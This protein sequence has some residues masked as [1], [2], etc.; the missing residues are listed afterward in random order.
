MSNDPTPDEVDRAKRWADYHGYKLQESNYRHKPHWHFYPLPK[1]F[2]GFYGATKGYFT[3]PDAAWHALALAL[4]PVFDSIAPVVREECARQAEL[5][6]TV[7]GG[8]PTT[9]NEQQLAE[10]IASA[11]RSMS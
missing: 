1:A 4:R 2:D 8:E 7:F 9:A 10:H 3:S 6:S 11:I 5:R